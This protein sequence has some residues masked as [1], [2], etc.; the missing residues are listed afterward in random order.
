MSRLVLL[1]NTVLVNFALVGESVLLPGLW[2]ETVCTT[3]AVRAEYLAGVA[4]GILPGEGW[5]EIPVLKLSEKER[6]LFDHLPRS[7]GAG[8]KSSLA[9]AFHR[10]G[11][12][13]TDDRKARRKAG[14]LGIS[15]TGTL[16]AL[17]LG[18]EKELLT[19]ER[20][21][22]LLKAMIE[23]GFHSPVSSLDGFL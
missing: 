18:V 1:D 5:P 9:M 19:L 10:Q 15:T 12:F 2:P 11:V 22:H 21:N 4:G 3:E 17:L 8:E 20:A 13:V 16:G 14:Q 23:E 6:E 7:L